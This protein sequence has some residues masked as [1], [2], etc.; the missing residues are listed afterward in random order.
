MNPT[1]GGPPPQNYGPPT[2]YGPPPQQGQ[3]GPPPQNYGPPTNYGQG[4]QQGYAQ[5][6][7]GQPQAGG[8]QQGEETAPR[9]ARSIT[10]GDRNHRPREIPDHVR[11]Q[12]KEASKE[13]DQVGKFPGIV[14]FSRMDP[15]ERV[16]DEET[17]KPTTKVVLIFGC[18][19]PAGPRSWI[20]SANPIT[21]PS[22]FYAMLDA[23]LGADFKGEVK[24]WH[25]KART[26]LLTLGH[27]TGE[28]AEK[29]QI[30]AIEP[31]APEQSPWAGQLR[32]SA[33]GAGQSGAGQPGPR[34][35]MGKTY[36]DQGP[37]QGQYGPPPQQGQY[38]PPTGYGGPPQGQYQQ[39]GAPVNYGP[40]PQ[41]GYGPPPG[42]PQY[43]GAPTQPFTGQF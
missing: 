2:N 25:F 29:V 31:L 10:V 9:Q 39:Q 24:D 19:T 43:A 27:G 34:G 12:Y 35:G 33:Q 3:Y 41:Q 18:P 20:W 4:G 8:Q 26:A 14:T 13:F 16:L 1:Q 42:A 36:G 7:P 37:P 11:A 30:N 17:G 40:P 21:S 5:P 23:L 38:G 28:Y 15:D 32:P 6:Q 22:R